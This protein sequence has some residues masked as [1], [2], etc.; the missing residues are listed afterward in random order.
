MIQLEVGGGDVFDTVVN[1]GTV[2]QAH[3]VSEFTP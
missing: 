2:F 1:I 3:H